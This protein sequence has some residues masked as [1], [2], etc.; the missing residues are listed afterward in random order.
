MKKIILLVED[1]PDHA[2]S[3]IVKPVSYGEFARKLI[4]M[5][6]SWFVNYFGWSNSLGAL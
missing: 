2:N 6:E 4:A 3:F 5:E 1:N